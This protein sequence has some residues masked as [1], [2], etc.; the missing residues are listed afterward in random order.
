MAGL[1]LPLQYVYVFGFDHDEPG[2]NTFDLDSELLDWNPS[3]SDLNIDGTFLYGLNCGDF[4]GVP[5]LG[6]ST[7]SSFGRRFARQSSNI[8]AFT[9]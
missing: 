6:H 5:S 1:R 2:T 7:H 4:V 9:M 8:A 3:S